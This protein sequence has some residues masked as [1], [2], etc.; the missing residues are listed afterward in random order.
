MDACIL[1]YFKYLSLSYI[2]KRLYKNRSLSCELKLLHIARVSKSRHRIVGL[3]TGRAKSF[4]CPVVPL[5]WTRFQ[6]FHNRMSGEHGMRDRDI[7][8]LRWYL[9]PYKRLYDKAPTRSV[10]ESTNLTRSEAEWKLNAQSTVIL[11][12]LYSANCWHRAW[13]CAKLWDL[14]S[15]LI[16]SLFPLV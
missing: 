11:I 3:D 7:V 15:L 4:L 1:Y 8:C 5:R 10:A 14:C 6:R 16:A 12:D 13:K 2:K 9:P